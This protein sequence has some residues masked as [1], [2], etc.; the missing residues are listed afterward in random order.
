M[1]SIKKERKMYVYFLNVNTGSYCI[2]IVVISRCGV[3]IKI[4][5]IMKTT[6]KRDKDVRTHPCTVIIEGVHNHHTESASALQQLRVLPETRDAF[7]KYFDL[8]KNIL[9]CQT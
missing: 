9:W 6:C 8:G 3:K 4:R 5:L 2:K 7:F 1:G